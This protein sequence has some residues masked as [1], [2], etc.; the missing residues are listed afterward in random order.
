VVIVPHIY[1]TLGSLAVLHKVGRNEHILRGLVYATQW[2]G[3]SELSI[4]LSK[5]PPP[6]YD[7]A[8]PLKKMGFS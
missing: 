5:M 3:I 1:C 7:A 6:S 2:G 4:L 8:S